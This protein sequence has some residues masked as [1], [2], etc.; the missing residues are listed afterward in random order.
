MTDITAAPIPRSDLRSLVLNE[1]DGWEPR[2]FNDSNQRENAAERIV[3]AYF[4]K[5]G[6]ILLRTP[7]DL[8]ALP[9]ASAVKDLTP[10]KWRVAVKDADQRWIYGNTM[11]GMTAYF[12]RSTEMSLPA[13][14]LYRPER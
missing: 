5:H 1:L 14:L 9:P 13:E 8:D 10:G 7:A 2:F 12:L 4:A 6:T 3:T 11:G